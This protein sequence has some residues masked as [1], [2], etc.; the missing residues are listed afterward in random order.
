MRKLRSL[1]QFL[2]D[3]RD[4]QRIQIAV[5]K[6]IA[7]MQCRKVDET[8]PR[9]WEFSGFSQN[10]EDGILQVLRSKLLKSNRHFGEIGAADG[11]QNNTAWLCAVERYDG[12]MIDGSP[13][14]AERAR[15][16]TKELNIGLRFEEMFVTRD[17]ASK[18][19]SL[20]PSADPDVFSLDIDGVDYYIAKSLFDVGVRPKIFVV[21]Y[22]SVFGPIRP[23]TVPYEDSFAMR[24]HPT[25][26]YYGVGL[27]AWRKLFESQGYR[28]VTVDVHGVN[29]FFVDPATIDAAFLANVKGLEFAENVYQRDKFGMNWEGQFALI[30][31]VKLVEV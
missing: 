11:I 31:G 26:L 12:L 10:G 30:N 2:Y 23:V 18:I 25:E 17:S 16:V 8:A 28:F 21:E 6:G 1:V 14:L 15:R 7:G 27:A 29:A 20:M 3:I 19:K 5:S 22:N 24:R 9:T 4:R 13:K